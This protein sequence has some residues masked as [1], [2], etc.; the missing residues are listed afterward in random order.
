MASKLRDFNLLKVADVSSNSTTTNSV[1]VVVNS[2]GNNSNDNQS[3]MGLAPQASENVNFTTATPMPIFPQ[4]TTLNPS[5]IPDVSYAASAS[6]QAAQQLQEL[7]FRL[8]TTESELKFYKLLSATLS[9]ILKDNN[10]KLIVNLIDQ[11][12]KIII[13]AP[14]LIELIAIKTNADANAVNITYKDEEA[15]CLA[16]VNPIKNIANIK[17]NNETFSLKYNAE[18]NIIQDDFNI[19]LEKV[20][21]PI[22]ITYK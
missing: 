17:I 4:S 8:N 14:T 16:K 18:Y 13:E 2:T 6:N 1:S 3:P 10:P 19:S 22:P 9:N 11:S 5:E 20:I 15:G 21:I 12:G 7:Q